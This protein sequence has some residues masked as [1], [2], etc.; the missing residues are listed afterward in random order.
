MEIYII[1]DNLMNIVDL[2]NLLYWPSYVFGHYLTFCFIIGNCQREV[3]D[4][5]FRLLYPEFLGMQHRL[6]LRNYL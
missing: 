6:R 1:N 5:L 4:F 2:I 3:H